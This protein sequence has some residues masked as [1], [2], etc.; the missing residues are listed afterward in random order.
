MDMRLNEYIPYI[1]LIV[2]VLSF[3]T[4]FYF[5]FRDRVRVRATST[6]YPPHPE[7]DRAHLVIRILNRG[8]RVAVLTMFGGDLADRS[9]QGENLGEKDRGLHLTEH[10]FYERKFYPEDIGAISP[11]SESEFVELWFEDSLGK[12]HKVKNS[13]KGIQQLKNAA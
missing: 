8:R 6:F 3:I 13:R 2:S 10:Q 9:W 7:Y 4:S 11:D 5:G 1:A 12:R